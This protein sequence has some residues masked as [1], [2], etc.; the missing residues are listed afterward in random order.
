[1]K[2]CIMTMTTTVA[3]GT[4][5]IAF[6]NFSF[7]NWNQHTMESVNEASRISHAKELLGK[8]YR[9]SY[10]QQL[11]GSRGLNVSIFNKVQAQLQPKWKAQAEKI[12]KAI[13]TESTKHEFDPIFVLAIIQTESQFN[14]LAIGS[15]GEIGLMQIRPETAAWIAKK[16][17]IA[18]NGPKTLKNPAMNVRIGV[19]YMAHLRNQ[20]DGAS[21]KYVS[22]YNM[23]PK[24]VQRMFSKKIQP[25]IYSTKV[26]NNYKDF[27]TSMAAQNTD[28]KMAAYSM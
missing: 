14:P 20:F 1:M 4:M 11:E 27:Y 17:G 13:I 19:A 26:M 12:S 5:M 9:G 18:W 8:Y 23:G 24:N 10:A 7:F 21:F 22:A 16:Y 2:K 28:Y 3:M 15:V 6:S 25:K